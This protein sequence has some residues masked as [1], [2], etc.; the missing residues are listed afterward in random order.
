M[1]LPDAPK[2]HKCICDDCGDVL[3][4]SFGDPRVEIKTFD[5]RDAKEP[6]SIRWICEWCADQ[7]FGDH[8]PIN[9]FDGTPDWIKMSL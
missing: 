7:R 1:V 4:D 6:S 5:S 3:D 2:K 8:S 9:I